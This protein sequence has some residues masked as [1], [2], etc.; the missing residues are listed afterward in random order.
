MEFALELLICYHLGIF[1]SCTHFPPPS[2]FKNID[3]LLKPETSPTYTL[4]WWW[5]KWWRS[6]LK[7]KPNFRILSVWCKNMSSHY[8]SRVLTKSLLGCNWPHLTWR[9]ICEKSKITQEAHIT[10]CF[11]EKFWALYK[12]YEDINQRET[13][14]LFS[15]HL[16]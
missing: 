15:K 10:P 2:P 13:K 5:N 14:S 9:T 1:P 3:T 11:F 6:N 4:V 8:V 16:S 7:S 12:I